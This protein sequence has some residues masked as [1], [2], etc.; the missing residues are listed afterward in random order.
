MVG[1]R[2]TKIGKNE[3]SSSSEL[4]AALLK[5]KAGETTDVV[6]SRDGKEV[7]VSVTLDESNTESESSSTNNFNPN[8]NGG[9][10]GNYGG[11]DG[12]GGFSRDNDYNS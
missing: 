11:Y 8:G 1:D 12:Y 2:I 10:Y 6:V 5:L 3:I 9:G 4:K 7:T